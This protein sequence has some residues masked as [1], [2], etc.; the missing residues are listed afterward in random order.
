MDLPFLSCA[1][2]AHRSEFLLLIGEQAIDCGS[3]DPT[4]LYSDEPE[5]HP[6]SARPPQSFH[7]PLVTIRRKTPGKNIRRHVNLSKV[8]QTSRNGT[9]SQHEPSHGQTP[10]R[11]VCRAAPFGPHRSI[12]PSERFFFSGKAPY[13]RPEHGVFCTYL[14]NHPNQVSKSFR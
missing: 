5:S 6:A 7:L 4:P 11:P 10:I 13:F 3:F 8:P 9:R 14:T 12:Y 1:H 2:P